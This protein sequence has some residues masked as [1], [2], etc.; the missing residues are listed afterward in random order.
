[1]LEYVGLFLLAV[2]IASCS[3]LLLKKSADAEHDSV[4]REY[5]NVRVMVG[6]ALMVVSALLVIFAYRGVELKQGP[7]LETMGY[8]F[9]LFLSW[10]FLNEK[11][12]KKRLLGVTLIIIGIV[13]TN[14]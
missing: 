5:L 12:T 11:P 14:I 6:Y 3:Q 13:V 9:V 4:L 2:F 7:I 1:M 10:A 8:V